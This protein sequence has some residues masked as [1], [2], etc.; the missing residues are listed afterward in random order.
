MNELL[1]IHQK[2]N[3]AV[4]LMPLSKGRI[5]ELELLQAIPFAHKVALSDILKNQAI[6]KY[7]EMIGV[8]T[9][10][11]KKGEWVHTHNC[12]SQLMDCFDYDLQKEDLALKTL[13]SPYQITGYHRFNKKVGIR[14]E[15]WI[16]VS[17][18]CINSVAK[19]LVSQFRKSHPISDNFDGIYAITHPF[20]CSQV[21]NDHENTKRILQNIAIHPNA[22]GVLVLG[23]GCENNQL[24]VFK[25]TM[26]HY[27]HQRIHFL[28]CQ[29]CED[30]IAEA[31]AHL[32]QLF[33]HIQKD[34]RLPCSFQDI[35]IGLKCGGSDGL[36]GITANPLVGR[37]CDRLI[38]YGASALLSEVPEMFGAE[39]LFMI[40]ATNHKV[41]LSMIDMI[42]R[43][44]QYFLSQ[45][46]NIDENPSF[47][48]KEGG[49]TTLEEKSLGCIQ[50]GGTT[51]VV[52]VLD[53]GDLQKQSGLSLLYGPGNDLVATTALGSAGAQ[54]VLFTTGRGTPFSGF[55]PTMKISTNSQLATKKHTW[56][57][58]NAG[59]VLEELNTLAI[60]E[61]F[62]KEIVDIINGKR[63]KSEAY[64][65][66]EIAIFKQG[67]M[68]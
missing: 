27:D 26:P 39:H 1:R 12:K 52:D 16:I 66:H 18:G 13:I 23:L 34:K 9:V 19:E 29:D 5:G 54:L 21:N 47:G 15:L 56:I 57:D 45:H 35:T 65:E 37:T 58:F 14:N 60:D 40:R 59:A 49:I 46:V 43:F 61:A 28:N 2:D 64:Q 6:I 36:S 31:L 51:Q 33:I 67:V 3:V 4:A 8:A 55:V 22:G 30:E 7:G 38:A 42:N 25:E 17:V 24:S 41:Y 20:G 50:K 44:K 11:I 62:M 63:V 32:E 53:Y 68:L 48:N 10:D